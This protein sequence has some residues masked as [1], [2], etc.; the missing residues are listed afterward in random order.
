M[1]RAGA[2]RS[3]RESCARLLAQALCPAASWIP[4]APEGRWRLAPSG[5]LRD[6]ACVN[7]RLELHGI[8]GKEERRFVAGHPEVLAESTD[9]GRQLTPRGEL[10]QHPGEIGTSRDRERDPAGETGVD[11]EH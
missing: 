3:V 8:T 7:E 1:W 10:Q 4:C 9:R 5:D 6:G 2:R 11:F